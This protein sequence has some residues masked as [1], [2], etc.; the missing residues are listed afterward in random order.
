MIALLVIHKI[1]IKSNS[2]PD[3]NQNP[4]M[5]EKI[6][7][8]SNCS[9]SLWFIKKQDIIKHWPVWKSCQGLFSP[10]PPKY[11]GLYLNKRHTK[12]KEHTLNVEVFQ[13]YD[14]FGYKSIKKKNYTSR[15]IFCNLRTENYSRRK[16]LKK[17][18]LSNS[19]HVLVGDTISTRTPLITNFPN[20]NDNRVESIMAHS[21]AQVYPVGN[22]IG[23]N[24]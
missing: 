23:E 4:E 14:R 19:L 18:F 24:V 17:P 5:K 21:R 8:T 16:Q 9:I 12:P 10:F 7:F 2:H 22:F 3:L 13:I 20:T 11:A 1:Y 15:F 6:F